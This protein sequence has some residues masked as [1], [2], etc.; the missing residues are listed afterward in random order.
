MSD[1]KYPEEN[2]FDRA[3]T[4]FLTGTPSLKEVTKG[5]E[6]G[7]LFVSEVHASMQNLL[8]GRSILEM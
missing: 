5:E 1:R 7:E 2:A 8:N 4:Q 3:S 6:E